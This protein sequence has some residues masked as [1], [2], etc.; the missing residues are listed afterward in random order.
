VFNARAVYP[1][2]SFLIRAKAIKKCRPPSSERQS[3]LMPKLS[4]VSR[5]AETGRVLC[6]WQQRAKT[7]VSSR[8]CKR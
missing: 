8:Q 2:I 6:P 7:H 5:G 1:E 3:G 4:G